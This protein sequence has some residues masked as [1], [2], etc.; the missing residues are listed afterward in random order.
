MGAL[1]PGSRILLASGNVVRLLEAD[2]DEWRCEY[3]TQ[4]RARGEVAFSVAFL[5]RG[6]QLTD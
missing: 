3:A 6:M 1:A 2:G 5:R 4:A